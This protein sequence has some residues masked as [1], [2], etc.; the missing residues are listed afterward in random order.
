MKT[1]APIVSVA[2]ID[3]K[4]E[5]QAS[6]AGAHPDL[7][8]YYRIPQLAYKSWC[9]SPVFQWQ[10]GTRQYSMRG[11]P[12]GMLTSASALEPIHSNHSCFLWIARYCYQDL[13]STILHYTIQ[14]IWVP[15]VLLFSKLNKTFVRIPSSRKGSF[16]GWPSPIFRLQKEPLSTSPAEY[17]FT[18]G[19]YW[20]EGCCNRYL[21]FTVTY[22]LG[23]EAFVN[24]SSS[25]LFLP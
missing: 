22:Y 23:L 17:H 14:S 10:A 1:A 18:F 12:L 2:M 13:M 9:N 24:Y 3:S 5:F 11:S 16:S 8:S 19:I 6:S 15:A 25:V 20:N 7:I 21:M 4:T